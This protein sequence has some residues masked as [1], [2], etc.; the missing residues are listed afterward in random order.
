MLKF[1]GRW[2][3]S[4]TTSTKINKP[5][6]VLFCGSDDFSI[7]SLKALHEYSKKSTN[8]ILSID[9]AARSDKPA[10][11]GLKVLKSPL[12]KTTAKDLN[13]PF[14]QFNTFTGWQPPTYDHDI[15]DINLIIAVSFGLLIPRRI[16]NLAEYGGLNVHPSLL[17]Q[18]RGA[19]PIN[20]S[21]INGDSHIGVS[22]QTLHP[23]KFDEGIV[24]AQ[25]PKIKVPN[26]ISVDE[27]RNQLAPIGGELLVKAIREGL[28]LNPQSVVTGEKSSLAPKITT[29]MKKLDWTE[30]AQTILRKS[31]GIPKLWANASRLV[32]RS[33]FKP[34]RIIFGDLRSEKSDIPVGIREDVLSRIDP[35]IPF[36]VM[37]EGMDPRNRDYPLFV[38]TGKDILTIPKIQVAGSTERPA[39]TPAF[40][41][42]LMKE[43]FTIDDY[44]VYG[45]HQPLNTHP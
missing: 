10:G 33:E 44:T 19:A 37:K 36:A 17:P 27:L 18:L 32:S 11:R 4:L 8:N 35:G 5:L 16:I 6:R 13:L 24:L 34:M 3:R 40:K 2:S 15:P 1:G 45:F 43:F 28:Y 22:V 14:H 7:A 39:S 29:Q 38:V 9:V 20:W 42:G 26:D 21:I 31:R 30:D 41:A 25:T 23:T 12:I